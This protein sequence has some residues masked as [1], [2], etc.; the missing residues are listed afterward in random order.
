MREYPRPYSHNFREGFLVFLFCI[1][2]HLIDDILAKRIGP[3]HQKE[4]HFMARSLSSSLLR[5]A[6]DIICRWAT[7]TAEARP[8]WA[9]Q[10]WVRLS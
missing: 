5:I 3:W 9:S 7:V 10:E 6:D 1:S 2:S 8:S 4:L